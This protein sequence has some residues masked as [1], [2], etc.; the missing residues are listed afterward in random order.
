MQSSHQ[1]SF[2]VRGALA[3]ASMLVLAG[4]SGVEPSPSP[5]PSSAS[6]V[7]VEADPILVPEGS[8]EENLPYFSMVLN[9]ARERGAGSVPELIDALSEAGFDRSA[10][11]MTDLLDS[12]GAPATNVEFS[13][14]WADACLLGQ[15]GGDRLRISTA[16]LLSQGT[17]LI[18]ST[19]PID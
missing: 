4:C 19:A 13:V 8:A 7:P 14:R 12:V 18:G 5:T 6:T 10:M 1:K 9:E 15:F 11:E 16:P 2:V 17:C 3:F